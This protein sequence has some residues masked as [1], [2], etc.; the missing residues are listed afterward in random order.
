MVVPSVVGAR[1]VKP[2]IAFTYGN[3]VFAA[4][5]RLTAGPIFAVDLASYAWLDLDAKRSRFLALV[6]ALEA[7]EADIQILR[8]SGSWD[9]RSFGRDLDLG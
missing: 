7:I 9:V 3:C 2:P 1:T 8:V 5:P 4:Q 6:G